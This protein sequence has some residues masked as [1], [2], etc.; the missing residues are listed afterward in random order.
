L[1]KGEMKSSIKII[2]H[3]KIDNLVA[4]SAIL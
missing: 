3:S 2:I 4:N 1:E